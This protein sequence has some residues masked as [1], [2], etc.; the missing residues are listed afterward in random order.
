MS[1]SILPF[2]RRDW[3]KSSACGFGY[4]ALAGLAAEAAAKETVGKQAG[5][6][7]A[8]KA[9]HFTPRA[10]RVIFMYMR[11]GPS[12]VDTFDYKP[13]LAEDAGKSVG[14]LSGQVQDRNRGRVLMASPWK[15]NPGGESGL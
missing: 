14:A 11:G 6:P 3:L 7:L 13:K 4:L 9:P 8:P 2:S 15:F 1:Q 5:N 10:K 12:H